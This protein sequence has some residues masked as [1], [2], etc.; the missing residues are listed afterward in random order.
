MKPQ[1]NLNYPLSWS[2]LSAFAWNRRDWYKKYLLGE[3]Q[4]DTPPLI[5]GKQVGYKLQHD[6]TFLTEVPRL[7]IFEK[8]LTGKLGDINLVGYLD[9]FSDNPMSFMEYKTSSNDTRW[10]QKKAEEH[11]QMMFYFLL[12]WLNYQIPPEEIEA[13]LVYIPCRENG[14]FDIELTGDPAQVFPV[15][16]TIPDLIKFGEFVKK[17]YANMQKYVESYPHP[18]PVD[19]FQPQV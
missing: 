6:P 7:P 16:K 14:A 4:P 2:S 1:F 9:A 18:L 8:K 10:S 15:K 5:F 17:T 19:T 12:I 11:G 3:R 13:A